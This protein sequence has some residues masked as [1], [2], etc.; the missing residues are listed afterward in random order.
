[1]HGN[2]MATEQGHNSSKLF[3][4]YGIEMIDLN[5]AKVGV[6]GSKSVAR[7]SFF[8]GLVKPCSQKPGIKPY[9]DRDIDFGEIGSQ[10]SI[11]GH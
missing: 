4:I 3:Q 7:S 1:M 9:P 6:E 8:K 5:V 10:R 11:I 2:N